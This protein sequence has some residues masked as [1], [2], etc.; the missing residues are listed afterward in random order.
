MPVITTTGVGNRNFGSPASNY[1]SSNLFMGG[2][3]PSH[4]SITNMTILPQFTANG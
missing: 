1:A 3:I 4:Q 2:T